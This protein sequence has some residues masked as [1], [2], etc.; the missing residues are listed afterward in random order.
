MS[1]QVDTHGL[2]CD[3]IV[4]DGLKGTTIGRVHQQNDDSN[5]DGSD[6]EGEDGVQLVDHTAHLDLHVVEVG[7]LTQQVGAVGDLAQAVP[8]EEGTED[9]CK[10]QGSNGQVVTLQTENGDT[11]QGCKDSCHNAADDDTDHGTDDVA[12]IG[13]QNIAQNLGNGELNGTAVK[14][15]INR[16]MLFSR[17]G[18]DGVGVGTD[19]HEA[20]LTQREQAGKA[21]E[22]VHGHADQGED[23]ALLKNG[24]QHDREGV[25][26]QCVI[27]QEQENVQN[28][29]ASRCDDG[30]GSLLGCCFGL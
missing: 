28:S 1:E 14:V 27:Q 6:Q 4:T 5:A 21:I 23:G 26:G 7:V 8:L 17:D 30:S 24:D 16:F 2:S 3:L 11:D 20:R 13:A 18:E 9:L 15:L 10:A 29:Q 19:E 22:Q 12:E 25:G